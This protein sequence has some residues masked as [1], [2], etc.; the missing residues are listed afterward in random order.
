MS[1]KA[2][3]MSIKPEYANLI[4]KGRK[5]VELRRRIPRH[6]SEGTLIFVYV[7][8]P[9]KAICGAFRVKEVIEKSVDKLWNLVG[10]DSCISKNDFV[11]YF[12]GLNNGTAIKIDD[13][14]YLDSPIYL[15]DT[16]NFQVPQ[17]FRY[18]TAEEYLYW[19]G[20]LTI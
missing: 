13:V 12:S 11:F 20:K 3:V 10:E 8:K 4:F 16:Q 15:C 19:G 17:S 18:A 6:I 2:L 9:I 7:T 5:T 1:N 14:W